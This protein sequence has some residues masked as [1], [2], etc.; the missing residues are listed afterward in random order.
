MKAEKMFLEKE[1]SS[2]VMGHFFDVRN[3]YGRWHKEKV[4][5]RVLVEKFELGELEFIDEPKISLYSFD[6][7]NKIAYYNPDFLVED[8]I[9]VEIKARKVL[10]PEEKGRAIEYLKTS[11]YEIIYL[12]NFREKDFSP[13]RFI[14]TNDRKPFLLSEDGSR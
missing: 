4:Y 2:N 10:T 11:K 13:Q 12:V 3:Q 6:T 1:L 8:K 7:G 14:F 5:H 9:L